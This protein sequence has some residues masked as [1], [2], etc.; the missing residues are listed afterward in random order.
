MEVKVKSRYLHISPRKLRPVINFVRGKNALQAKSQLKFQP[1]KG[2]A[3]VSNLLDSALAVVKSSEV[4][5]ESFAISAI[6]C[7]DGPRLKRGQPVSKGK[8]TPI[9]K[10]QSHLTLTLSSDSEAKKKVVE[11]KENSSDDSAKRNA[12]VQIG[13]K[14]GSKS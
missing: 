3:M 2:A 10:R 4:T 1:N 7:G 8:M 13:E 14:N 11:K 6:A 5:P 12:G 9:K